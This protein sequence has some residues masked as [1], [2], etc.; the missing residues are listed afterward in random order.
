ML[1]T[2]TLREKNASQ[3]CG[4]PEETIQSMRAT[5]FASKGLFQEGKSKYINTIMKHT[6]VNSESNLIGS[7][8]KMNII[9]RATMYD[10]NHMNQ[11]IQKSSFAVRPS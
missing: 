8:S 1:I 4:Q 7:P 10:P 9:D 11:F 5:D 3:H 6:I 2:N